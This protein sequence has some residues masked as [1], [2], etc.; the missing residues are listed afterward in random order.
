[1]GWRPEI[2]GVVV[3]SSIVLVSAVLASLA[4]GVLVAYGVCI[5]MFSAFQMHA[6]QIAGN[7]AR[8]VSTAVQVLKS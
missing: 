5:A 3:N 2:R 8:Q 6:R 1:M 7:A 4:V